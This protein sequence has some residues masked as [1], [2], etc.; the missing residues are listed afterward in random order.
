MNAR[1]CL[2]VALTL[3]VAS[4]ASAGTI[5]MRPYF[6]PDKSEV[7]L[8][9]DESSGV[10]KG[11]YY[12]KGT[13]KLT[14]SAANCQLPADPGVKGRV[15][16]APY[17]GPDGTEV[18]LV[19]DTR[20]GKSVSWYFD[21]GESKFKRAEAG[22]Q[23]PT[24]K[25]AEVMLAPYLDK[26]KN[27]VVLA[28]DAATGG[29]INWYHDSEE[30]KFKPSEPG[31]QLPRHLRLQGRVMMTPYLTKDGSEVIY[32]W[33]V[34]TGESANWYYDEGEKRMKRSDA[35]YQLPKNPGVSHDV[36]MYPYS[37]N[38]GTEVVL[39]WSAGG[40][41]SVNWYYDDGDKKMKRS[42]DGYQLPAGALTGKSIMMVPYL[43]P[44]ASEVILLWDAA[45]GASKGFYY[46][47]EKKKML[48]AEAGYQL[49][50]NPLK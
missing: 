40:G 25:G 46:D 5:H 31:Y 29:S 3:T 20:S 4:K 47:A 41:S 39:V 27:E 2:V 18:V 28:W 1:A 11:W 13:K 42:E 17:L 48:P 26:A 33:S 14:P 36:W 19:W 16:M 6:G 22:F 9:W 35:G 45:S 34:T 32:T 37:D 23:L 21:A 8:V 44:E 38:G 7:V 24:Q 15:M 10:S 49:P 12:D 43:D 30:Q 50:A